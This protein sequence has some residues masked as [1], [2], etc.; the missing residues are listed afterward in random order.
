VQ[1]EERNLVISSSG[2]EAPRA[3][4][5]SGPRSR[6]SARATHRVA[7]YPRAVGAGP[8]RWAPAGRRIAAGQVGPLH[9]A[10]RVAGAGGPPARAVSRRRAPARP[11]HGGPPARIAR[12]VARG[13]APQRRMD[14]YTG[15]GGGARRRLMRLLL[16][17]DSL[18]VPC[19]LQY[20]DHALNMRNVALYAAVEHK[21]H[22]GPTRIYGPT[23]H[24]IG[25]TAQ[26]AL[27]SSSESTVTIIAEPRDYH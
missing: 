12:A 1:S 14:A 26:Q 18:P 11:R 10:P 25:R 2:D 21:S 6:K 7:H 16:H 13:P 4:G 5:N 8:A 19:A 9:S 20:R 3:T 15:R 22:Y 27:R 17:S 23:G 24:A